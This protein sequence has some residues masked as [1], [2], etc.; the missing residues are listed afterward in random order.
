MR[1]SNEFL[2]FKLIKTG[3]S[4]MPLK[5]KEVPFIAAHKHLEK[6]WKDN[7]GKWKMMEKDGEKVIA[8]TVNEATCKSHDTQEFEDLA[9]SLTRGNM[10]NPHFLKFKGLVD[11]GENQK[12]FLFH[13]E[14]LWKMNRWV[15]EQKHTNKPFNHS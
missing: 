2:W 7:S 6:G 1:M 11:E 4:Q 5:F 13:Y 10:E 9:S 12:F 14:N 3:W 15:D 8:F